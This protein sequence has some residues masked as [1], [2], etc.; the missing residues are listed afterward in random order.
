MDLW[1]NLDKITSQLKDCPTKVLMLDF[2]GTLTP[3][4]K[5]PNQVKLS[6]AMK[7]LLIKLS[8]KEGFYLAILSGRKLKDLKKRVNLQ[9]I[10]YA[11]NHG[12]EGEIFSEKYLFPV[13]DKVLGTL[14]KIKKQLN[15]ITDKFKGT[16]I[17]DKG[18]TLSF[19]Y[20]LADKHQTQEIKLLINQILKAYIS[21]GLISVIA[22]KKVI[23]ITPNVNWSKGDFATL[24]IKKIT[25]RTKNRPVAIVIGDD[26]TDESV[27]RKLKR[28][29]TVKVDRNLRSNAK[30]SLKNTKEVYRFLSLISNRI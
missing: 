12:L 20:R 13:P 5:S 25:D 29:I 3:I 23:D 22:G 9:N 16:F 14:G 21:D 19:H 7:N 15:Q 24:V 26:T 17:E 11:G 6:K 2:D 4:I 27:F 18:L 1:K 28:G 30:Y 10:I 8:K